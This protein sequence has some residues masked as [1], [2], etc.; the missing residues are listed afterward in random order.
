MTR[1]E[2]RSEEEGREGRQAMSCFFLVFFFLV[3][4]LRLALDLIP[5]IR[6]TH[7][8]PGL[9]RACALS[10]RERYIYWIIN[11]HMGALV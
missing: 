7:Y 5:G 4:N 6:S 11:T 3:R 8:R 9:A 10:F 1:T 2:W